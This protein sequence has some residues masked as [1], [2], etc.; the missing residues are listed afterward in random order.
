M[1]KVNLLLT[2][3][4][5]SHMFKWPLVNELFCG[6]NSTQYTGAHVVIAFGFVCQLDFW[7]G[8]PHTPLVSMGTLCWNLSHSGAAALGPNNLWS[9]PP[10][11]KDLPWRLNWKNSPQC[12]NWLVLDRCDGISRV[13]SHCTSPENGVQAR[14]NMETDTQ[15]K[16]CIPE[17]RWSGSCQQTEILVPPWKSVL[18]YLYAVSKWSRLIWTT[19]GC[20]TYCT[21]CDHPRWSCISRLTVHRW[22]WSWSVVLNSCQGYTLLILPYVGVDGKQIVPM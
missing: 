3:Q 21:W 1:E 10:S 8:L 4:G 13:Y 6:I 7:V 11:S 5:E 16:Q 9:T 14:Y 20:V 18:G 15:S 17:A 2:S 22:H 19:L 12:Q